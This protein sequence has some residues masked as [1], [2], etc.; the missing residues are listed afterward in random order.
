[1]SG[2]GFT[3]GGNAPNGSA[4]NAFL[5]AFLTT[6]LYKIVLATPDNNVSKL[7]TTGYY[8]QFSAIA[9]NN[10]KYG[11]VLASAFTANQDGAVVLVNAP[12]FSYYLTVGAATA[13]YPLANTNNCPV[14]NCEYQLFSNNYA[15]FVYYT[16]LTSSATGYSVSG[17][18]YSLW[19]TLG[20]PGG[21]GMATSAPTAVTSLS[22]T[23]GTA[24][25]FTSGEIVNVTSGINSGS[26]FAV[27]Q[28]IFDVYYGVGGGPTGAL[29]MPTSNDVLQPDGSHKQT[30]ELG[31]ITYT[32]GNPPTIVLP[33][34]ELYVTPTSAQTLQ[35]G[36][37][38]TLSASAFD[39]G[40]QAA[41]GRAVSWT[42]S[43]SS[44]VS[45]TGN[46]YTATVKGVGNGI[47]NIT[48]V[49]EGIVSKAITITAIEPCCQVGQG[50][51]TTAM[52][53][54]FQA[55]VTRNKITVL[56]PAATTAR[57]SGNGYI[58][59]LY[60]PDGTIHYLVAEPTAGTTAYIL[61]GPTLAAY[62][63]LNGPTGTLGYPVSD[64]S[65][66]GTQ[67]FQGGALAGSP[68]QTVT[69]PIFNK[70]ASLNYE[71]GALGV[72]TAAQSP[73]ASLSGYAGFAQT[74][75]GGT[76]F[77]MTN[78]PS[79][80]Q[81][82]QSSGPILARYQA[83]SGPS[84]ALGVPLGDPAAT[85]GGVVRQN[86]ENGYIDLQPS[87][88]TAVEHLNPKVPSVTVA[89]SSVLP[90][91]KVH[92][93]I[94]GFNNGA[95][96]RV[97]QTGQQD[98]LITVPAGAYSWDAFIASNAAA[99][100]ITVKA[101]DTS[102][103]ATAATGTY[104]IRT[105]A[106]A[107]PKIVKY[108]GDNQT[109]PP[110]STL[111]SPLVVQITDS[112]GNAIQGATVKFTASS[113]TLT[114]AST[115]TDSNGR[116]STSL[117]LPL[118][119]GITAV[120]ATSLGQI[121]IFDAQ[122]AGSVS[123]SSY[124]QFAAATGP[125]AQVAA[126]A[127]MIRYYQNIGAMPT[128]NGQATPTVIDQFLQ[129]FTDGYLNSTQLVN[130]WRL[131]NFTGGKM[132]V[133]VENTDLTT[134]RTLIAG[135]DPVLL[136]LALVQDGTPS[137]GTVVVATGVGAD[138]SVS[139][140]D[141]NVLLA[142][143]NLNG[144]LYGFTSNGHNFTGTVIS[145]LRLLPQT[146]AANGFLL[147][148]ISQ[149]YNAF[150]SLAVQSA[151]GGCG[152]T[153][154]LQDAYLPGTAPPAQVL[155]SNF[156]Y[157]DGSQPVYQASIGLSG[158]YSASVVDLAAQPG[159]GAT[160]VNGSAVAAYQISRTAGALTVAAPSV[161]FTAS[162]VLNAASFQ[163]GIAPGGLFSIFGSGLA[164]P[165][166]AT[167]VIVGGQTAS[168]L[169]A[170]PFQINAQVPVGV[171]PGATNIQIT[172]PY[173][174]SVQNA[175]VQAAA[176]GIFVIGTAS[177]GTSS[178]GAVVN[179]TGTLNGP[180]TP[181]LRGST[182]TIYGTGL[183]TTTVKSGLSYANGTVTA[184]LGGTA[185]PVAFAGLTPGFVGLYQVNLTIPTA[186]A[187]GLL[188]PL[189]IQEGSA[190]SNPVVVAIQ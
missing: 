75:A 84:G 72:P 134:L 17:N 140:M 62:T 22:K 168:V 117:R 186:T 144:Y 159:S 109:A 79:A 123:L 36:Q 4:A 40:G 110:G 157:C 9:D 178:L 71:T 107:Q 118:T 98:F 82:F 44:A 81:A 147:E 78:G 56:I 24:Q 38:L 80:G 129:T 63:A 99:G 169:L 148:A 55:A 91:T 42:T 28:P 146:P 167:A 183:G 34:A 53:A 143:T 124:P 182:V 163:P 116:A 165:G 102:A 85:T 89:P 83:L 90:G 57:A 180:T 58:Q 171:A 130:F 88:S 73:F 137:S 152:I 155:A 120:T 132:N 13:G 188:I 115:L 176:P 32:T 64:L 153:L 177:D 74:F 86:F 135:G 95:S 104:T 46:G 161:N 151:A 2:Q 131:A 94:A 19:T 68:I 66:G 101:L 142:Q 26:T 50:T 173:G 158:A 189:S 3:V 164:G 25:L 125:G 20:G 100:I 87:A 185:L 39:S 5:S 160:P 14:V 105:I 190:V 187:P 114:P 162:S 172:S 106:A 21:V 52:Q 127:S 113:G 23:T 119:T 141:P 27:T 92:F 108:Q 37:T 11:L 150:P 149:P 156:V 18:I 65:A 10:V 16:S 30:F 51:P 1:L 128:T 121:A 170:T 136:S 179:Q 111:A 67:R 31:R 97:S 43:N 126:A 103:A 184:N 138:G 70:W 54:A 145:A 77:G 29:G 69:G 61:T 8:Q 60:S 59:D 48:A 7:G 45:V 49:S 122:S 12:M 175:T 133:S 76:I 154:T 33:V 181:A 6:G 35:Y 96:L 174:Y 166:P 41:I 139:I 15:L 112:A 93:S 47:A